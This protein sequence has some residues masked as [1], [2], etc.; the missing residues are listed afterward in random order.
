MSSLYRARDGITVQ[1]SK[2]SSHLHYRRDEKKRKSSRTSFGSDQ[3]HTE[4]FRIFS[5]E[6]G[7]QESGDL[8]LAEER[9]GHE[10]GDGHPQEPGGGGGRGEEQCPEAQAGTDQDEDPPEAEP[11]AGQGVRQRGVPGA[12]GVAPQARDPAQAA[13]V[14]QGLQE[15]GEAA[16]Q[17]AQEP[18]VVIRGLH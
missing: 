12:A 11:G 14:L 15:G 9:D 18:G 3:K 7:G 10:G 5:E 17:G 16:L 13:E 4:R 8:N 6:H 1:R 2:L